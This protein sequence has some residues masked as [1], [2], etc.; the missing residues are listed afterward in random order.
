MARDAERPFNGDGVFGH[1]HPVAG[2]PIVDRLARHAEHAR[3]R[4]RCQTIPGENIR[5]IHH[6]SD[7][8]H[9]SP[10]RASGLPNMER[11]QPLSLAQRHNI[12][13]TICDLT[14]ATSLVHANATW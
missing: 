8:T 9:K 2:D 3:N 13:V 5:Q 11:Q 7:V 10:C 14:S 4:P 12:H 6:G 1:H